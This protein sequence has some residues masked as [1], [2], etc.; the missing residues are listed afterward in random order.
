MD[1]ISKYDGPKYRRYLRA[2]LSLQNHPITKFDSYLSAFVKLEKI[3]DVAKDPRMIQYRSPRYCVALGNYLKAIEHPLYQMSGKGYLKHWLPRGRLI[4]KQ[5]NQYVR[6]VLIEQKWN[7]FKRPVA[8]SLDCSR[9]D[10]H[11][12]VPLLKIEHSVYNRVFQ[13]KQLHKLLEWQLV[14][15]ASSVKFI[16]GEKYGITYEVAGGRMSGD[17]NTALGNCL[18]MVIMTAVA[19]KELGFTPKQWQLMDDGDDCVIITSDCYLPILRDNLP[20]LFLSYGHELKIENVAHSLDQLVLC[21]CQPIRVGG[22]RVM[23]LDP[24]R[25]MGKSRVLRKMNIDRNRYVATVGHCSLALFSGVPIL[26]AYFSRMKALGP[27]LTRVPTGLNYRLNQWLV[28]SVQSLESPIE[29]ETRLDFS[30]AFG[31][32]PEEQVTAEV[33]LQSSGQA[34]F[35]DTPVPFMD[36]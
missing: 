10:A 35:G 17:M 30:A 31:I 18:L 32:S 27:P 11:C 36:C 34:I 21:G 3:C 8:L 13:D 29:P 26:Q 7:Q 15:R 23:I 1:W 24:R 33:I 16:D 25:A 20:R 28:G 19:M 6:G 5:L 4:A 9:F 2:L 12:S 22:R 14:N